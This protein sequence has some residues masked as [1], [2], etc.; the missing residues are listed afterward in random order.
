M[1]KL[2]SVLLIAA[3]A[4]TA[5][6]KDKTKDA[7][8]ILARK[9]SDI[10]PQKYID[11]LAK[12]GLVI[13]DGTTPPDVTG[14]YDLKPLVLV[15]SNRPGDSPG[16]TFLDAKLKLYEQ[17]SKTFDIR[18]LGKMFL[19]VKDSSLQTAV[20]GSGNSF[21]VYGKVEATNNSNTAIFAILITGTKD[22]SGA[23]KNVVYGLIN[24]DNSKGG[25]V[26]IQEGEARIVKDNDGTS[27]I[28]TVFRSSRVADPGEESGASSL[29]KP[30]TA[31]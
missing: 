3:V 27:D 31:Q 4:I 28:A 30:V 19:N 8:E 6:K 21:T 15:K 17:N 7:E 24:I 25:S 18:L 14:I 26:F 23:L 2:L 29:L 11:T 12:L 10:I 9:I 5:C 16:M 20:S 22:P 1:R 13:N